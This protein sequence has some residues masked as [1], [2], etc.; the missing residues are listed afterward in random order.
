MQRAPLGLWSGVGLVVANVV[1]VGVLTN[2][3]YMA[4]HL[5]PGAIMLCW[6]AGGVMAMCGARCYAEL[7]R[8]I[9]RSG[10]EYRYLSDLLHP[11]WGNVAGW[12]SIL[13]GFAAPVALAGATAGP[14]VATLVPGAP[15]RLT[16]AALIVLATASQAFHL[17]WSTATQ[18]VLA[19]IKVLLIAGFIAVGLVLGAHALPAWR[20][21]AAA[22]G[23][24]VKPFAVSLVYVAFAFSGWNAAV[25]AAEEFRDPARTVPRAMLLGTALVTVVYLVVNAILVANLTGD[26]L[27]AWLGEDTSRI[28]LAHLLMAKLAGPTAARVTS[29]LV[30][31]W[32]ASSIVSMTLSGPRVAAAMAAEGFLPRALAGTAGQPPRWS[33]LFQSGVALVLLATHSFESLLRSVGAILTLA[34]A[35]AVAALLWPRRRGTPLPR[36]SL[37]VTAAASVYLLGS[38]WMLWFS[39][40]DEPVTLVWVAVVLIAAALRRVVGKT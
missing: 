34:S 17:R 26:R 18:D 1:G 6:L 32:L 12:T 7:A 20:A 25:Y 21:P 37:G 22:A 39:F 11:F 27:S 33:V 16:G 8:A 5:G 15:P 9:P 24:P 13:V 36:A 14:F 30:V 10:G 31:L 4:P 29:L 3:G 40:A 35:L 19:L 38:A 23:L 28:T 2:T